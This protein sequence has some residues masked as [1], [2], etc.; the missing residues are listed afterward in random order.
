L[1]TGFIL[2]IMRLYSKYGAI[3]TCNKISATENRSI[4][5]SQAR[6]TIDGPLVNSLLVLLS[7]NKINLLF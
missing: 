3:H 6:L 7:T 1:T 2:I 5:T 4:L